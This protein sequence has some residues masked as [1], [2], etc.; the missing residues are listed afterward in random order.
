[1]VTSGRMKT[2]IKFANGIKK[3]MKTQINRRTQMNNTTVQYNSK[4]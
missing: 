4:K 3:N 2:F 1:M